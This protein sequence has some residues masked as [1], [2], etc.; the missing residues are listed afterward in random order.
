MDKAEYI[1][2]FVAYMVANAG[3]EKFDCG[4]PVAAY[5]EDCANSSW[6]EGDASNY[7]EAEAAVDME[8]WGE[9]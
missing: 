3:F 8:Y 9:E 5:A 2:R 6:D 4:T 1:R 7:P